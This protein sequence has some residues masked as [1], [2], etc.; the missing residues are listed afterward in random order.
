MRV[1]PSPLLTSLLILLLCTC[2]RAPLCRAQSPDTLIVVSKL[3]YPEARIWPYERSEQKAA[4]A[5]AQRAEPS[6]LSSRRR[7]G[8]GLGERATSVSEHS[9]AAAK[10]HIEYQISHIAYLDTCITNRHQAQLAADLTTLQEAKKGQ[11]LKYLPTLS[12]GL[13]PAFRQTTDGAFTSR[14]APT[15]SLGVNSSLIYQ[16]HRDRQQRAAAREAIIQQNRLK[17]AAE[18]AQFRRLERRLQVEIDKLTLQDGVADIDRQLFLLYQKQYEN[19]DISP[20]EYLLKRR[21]FLLQELRNQQQLDRIQTLQYQLE[22]LAG[23][24][25]GRNPGEELSLQ[26]DFFEKNFSPT[27]RR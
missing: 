8:E 16:S 24:P 3:P 2:V 1:Q 23:C 25:E 4:A 11:W 27:K 13:A 12:A 5:R 17:E 22:D 6:P 7:F 26:P 19:H 9:P 10:S 14:L 18:I 20:E 15:L 21:A